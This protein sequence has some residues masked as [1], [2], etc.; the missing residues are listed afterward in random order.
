MFLFLS[1][2]ASVLLGLFVSGYAVV[3]G[4]KAVTHRLFSPIDGRVGDQYTSP[5]IDLDVKPV[6][7]GDKII[8]TSYRKG[9]Y[10][11]LIANRRKK[12]MLEIE[13]VSKEDLAREVQGTFKAWAITGR[14]KQGR[15]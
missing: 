13:S 5:F 12:T 9:K 10:I 2:T 15:Y 8:Y 4:V 3:T 7:D 14:K 11:A 1:P 6:S